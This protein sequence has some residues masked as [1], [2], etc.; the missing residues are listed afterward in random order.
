MSPVRSIDDLH[1]HPLPANR[2]PIQVDRVVR[3]EKT[4]VF[5]DLAG[6]IYSTQVAQRVTYTFGFGLEDTLRGCQALGLLSK[7]AVDQ[8]KKLCDARN[9]A[10]GMRWAAKSIAE[11]AA[12]LGLKF[13]PAQQRV[14]KAAS[15]AKA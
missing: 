4:L 7:A 6:R 12:T 15:E 1:F 11:D 2:K 13:T 14:I 8:H 9:R 3:V 10:N 5:V